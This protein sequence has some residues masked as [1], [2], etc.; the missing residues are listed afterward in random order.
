MVR[1]FSVG[2]LAGLGYLLADSF[3]PSLK[4]D[5]L[6]KAINL[7][8]AGLAGLAAMHFLHKR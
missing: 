5:A 6:N 4:M 8:A 2:A 1:A 7:T 3:V